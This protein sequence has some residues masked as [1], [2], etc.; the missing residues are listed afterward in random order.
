MKLNKIISSKVVATVTQEEVVKALRHA[1]LDIPEK[2]TL[3]FHV[4]SGGDYS[5][6]TLDVQELTI[7]WTEVHEVKE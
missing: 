3:H 5:G 6:E 4:P 1:G 7:L 2:C